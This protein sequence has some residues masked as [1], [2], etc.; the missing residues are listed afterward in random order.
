M[1][2]TYMMQAGDVMKALGVSRSKAY[3]IIR[4]LNQMLEK[5]GYWVENGKIPR[6]NLEQK[7]Y[8]FSEDY[9]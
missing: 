3:D 5:E 7:F 1:K 6:P 8:G 4:N 9:M 2:K